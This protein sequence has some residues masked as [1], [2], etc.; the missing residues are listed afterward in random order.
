MPVSAI[1]EILHQF[2]Y[3]PTGLNRPDLI[4]SIL[5]PK[6]QKLSVSG[7]DTVYVGVKP[8]FGVITEHDIECSQAGLAEYVVFMPD[9]IRTSRISRYGRVRLTDCRTS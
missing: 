1:S 5:G 7:T 8:H 3:F 2:L 4:D 6:L 9:S